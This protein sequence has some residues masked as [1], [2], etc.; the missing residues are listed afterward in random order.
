M[1]NDSFASKVRRNISRLVVIRRIDG[2][3]PNDIDGTVARAEKLLRAENYQEAL[4]CLISLDQNYH[5]IL[6]DFL[7]KLSAASD[8]KKIDTEILSYLKSL[9]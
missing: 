9:N 7:S 1:A 8:I 6:A 5:T 2:K 4:E 3:N